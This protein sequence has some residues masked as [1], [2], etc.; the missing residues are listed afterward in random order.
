MAAE[1]GALEEVRVLIVED[2]PVDAKLV[3]YALREVQDWQV[4][5]EIVEDGEDAISYLN[6]AGKFRESTRPDL[7][8]LDLNLPKRTGKEVLQFIRSD[9]TLR[10]MPVIILSS[11]PMDIIRDEVRS[12]DAQPNCYFTK[13]L[14]LDEFLALGAKMRDCYLRAGQPGTM[15]AG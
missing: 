2:N 5:M 15:G 13:P 14:G 1:E 3:R 12:A 8:V 4:S 9:T 6:H 11:S 7:V 10:K